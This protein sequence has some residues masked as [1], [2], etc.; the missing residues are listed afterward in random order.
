[1]AKTDQLQ[2]CKQYVVTQ[3]DNIKQQLDQ[4]NLELITQA[5]TSLSSSSS[6]LMAILLPSQEILDRCLKEYVS[7]QQNYLFRRMDQQLIKYKDEI[8]DQQ[9]YRHLSAY[10]ITIAQ[11]QA[12]QQLINLR[13]QQLEVFEEVIILNERILYQF[14]PSN[15][16]QLEKYIVQDYYWPPISDHTLPEIKTKRRKLLRQIKRTV[17]NMYM[18]AYRFKINNYQQ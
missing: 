12:I 1:M 6:S 16:D 2:I 7:L 17:L 18:Y 10:N 8:Y 5:Q 9:L 14:L 13:Q 11:Q 3:L 4:C 15:F